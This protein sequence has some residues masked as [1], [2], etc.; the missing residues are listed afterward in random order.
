ML[1][2]IWLDVTKSSSCRGCLQW[3]FRHGPDFGGDTPDPAALEM[4]KRTFRCLV[5]PDPRGACCNR[6]AG[7]CGS[8][9]GWGIDR[10][11]FLTGRAGADKIGS[12][13]SAFDVFALECPAW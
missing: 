4:L 12:E 11:D 3:R 13:G 9:G 2:S 7:V 5:L 10:L 6:E 8:A 1:A